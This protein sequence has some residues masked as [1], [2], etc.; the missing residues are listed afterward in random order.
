MGSRAFFIKRT[1]VLKENLQQWR[2]VGMNAALVVLGL[3]VIV[4]LYALATR[5]FSPG[6][7]PTREANPGG[8]VG[9]IIQVEVRNG[10]GVAGL[11][12]TATH[13]LRSKGFDVVEVG[14]HTSFDQAQSVVVDRV[15]NL[16]AAKKVA[17][18]MGIPEDRVLQDLRPDYFLDASII[19]GQDY[20]TLS[21]FAEGS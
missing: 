15:G 1:P 9:D 3:L 10:C 17:A 11:G 12:S 8:L 13:F 7:D 18:V 20:Q 16:E 5:I 14:N 21:P 4:L 19:L 6:V 2:N